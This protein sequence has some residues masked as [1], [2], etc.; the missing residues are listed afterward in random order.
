MSTPG[1]LRN[2]RGG[3]RS[4]A[5]KLMTNLYELLESEASVNDIKTMSDELDNQLKAIIKLDEKIVD[6]LETEEEMTNELSSISEITMK[7][8]HCLNAVKNHISETHPN[9]VSRIDS[10]S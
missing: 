5:T 3:H 2:K 4:Q 6:S 8:K 1:K 10:L 9:F 7:I